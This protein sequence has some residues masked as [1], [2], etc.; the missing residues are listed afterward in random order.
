V[1]L[2]LDPDANVHV[3]PPKPATITD[4]ATIKRLTALIDGLPVFPAG[5]YES[6]PFDAGAQLVLTFSAARA[7][8]ALAVA[9]VKLEGCQGVELTVRGQH[10][11]L[12][13][14]LSSL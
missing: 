8:P 10:W 2:S 7:G 13:T 6:C 9:T 11:N 5:A 14:Y 1:T 12:G 4:P 3:K